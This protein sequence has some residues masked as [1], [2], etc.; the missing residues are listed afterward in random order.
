VGTAGRPTALFLHKPL[1]LEGPTD[2]VVSP[3]CMVPSARARLLDRLDRSDVG[4]IV[5]GHLHQHRDRIVGGQRHLWVPAVA[6]AAA[7]AHGGDG[8]CGVAVLDFSQDGVE[9]TIERPRGMVSHDLA[10]IK[11]HGRYQF[12]RDMPPCPPPHA[13]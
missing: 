2:D 3:A 8:R 11:G 9:V 6:F 7:Q 10:A 12:L 5:S 1:F 13:D 4:L